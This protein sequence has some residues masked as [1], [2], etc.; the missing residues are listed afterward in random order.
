MYR[1]MRLRGTDV[2]SWFI[3]TD[4]NREDVGPL[5]PSDL[6]QK[7]RAGEVTRETLLRK[8]DSA[9][10]LAGTVGG[11]FEAA[12][13]PTI[14]Y[15]CPQCE[16]SVGEPPVVCHYCGREI[17][18]AVTKITENTITDQEDQTLTEQAGR[19]VQNWLRKKR[20][21]R[22]QNENQQES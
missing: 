10:F 2:T 18:Q 8:D 17:R 14:E 5:R 21:K 12:M 19:S 13:R 6:L 15:F 11:L 16:T 9:W 20:A 7:V 1:G 4:D 3:Q 22:K